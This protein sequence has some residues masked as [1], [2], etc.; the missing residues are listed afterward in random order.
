M[1]AKKKSDAAEELGFTAA[2]RELEGILAGIEGE[3]V[4]LDKLA[5]ELKRAAE[6]LD[7][8]RAK[9]RKADLEVSQIVQ[10]LEGEGGE[11]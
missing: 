2:I 9:I 3:D 7:L 6:L 8:C 11:G 10:K 1:T 4:D 5:E